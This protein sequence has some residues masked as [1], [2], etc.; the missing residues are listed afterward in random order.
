MQSPKSSP[1]DLA[2][3]SALDCSTVSAVAEKLE[4]YAVEPEGERL[5]KLLPDGVD[6]CTDLANAHR[7]IG[8]Y[9]NDLRFVGAWGKWMAWSGQRWQLDEAGQHMQ[10]GAETTKR[11]FREVPALYEAGEAGLGDDRLKWAKKSQQARQISAM[12]QLA[13]TDPRVAVD[14]DAFD[15]DPWLL[16]VQ[17]GTVDLRTGR[18]RPHRREDLITKICPVAFDPAARCPTWER[19]V[20]QVMGDD[21]ELV[22]YLQ[23]M[24]GY[25]LTGSIREHV[26]GFFFGGGSNGKTTFLGAIR[27]VLGDYA[28]HAARGLLI[29]RREQHP[30]ELTDLLGRR[31]V[32]C[33]EIEESDS[34]D[35]AL[36]KDLTGGE[37]VKARRMRED[38]WEFKPT[39]KLFIAGNHKPKVRGTDDGIWRRIRLVPFTVTI[40][41]EQKD[42]GLPAKLETEAPGILAWAVRGCLEWQAQ[43]LGDPPAVLA[44]T[45]EYR[46][47]SDTLGSFFATHLRFDSNARV[48]KSELVA[49]LKAWSDEIG[50]TRLPSPRVVA[51]RLKSEGVT[52]ST[53][54]VG[55]AVKECWRGVEVRLPLEAVA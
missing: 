6:P 35:E 8:L 45:A 27:H 11:I 34:F 15:A 53:M 21:V 7:M 31:F 26:L 20:S 19:F 40:P 4:A 3:I 18:V 1:K 39:H 42:K 38:F 23:R 32:T 33:A 12:V 28:A 10:L 17:N 46:K 48:L 47:D 22:A 2:D 29:K 49:R 5:P 43:G 55:L 16:N 14:H 24:I 36:V 52:E 9:G 54:R 44:A 50:L 25:A 30:T 13:K 51:A 41:D 37:P